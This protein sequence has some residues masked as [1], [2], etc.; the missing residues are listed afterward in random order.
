MPAIVNFN[1]L[2]TTEPEKTEKIDPEIFT[3]VCF[4][5][6]IN[7]RRICGKFY[8]RG[9]NFSQDTTTLYHRKSLRY[10]DFTVVTF[11]L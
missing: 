9:A 2:R 1:K 5:A 11:S 3:C 10:R 8:S 6:L 4:F 7:S